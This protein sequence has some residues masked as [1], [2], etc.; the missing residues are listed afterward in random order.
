MRNVRRSG[1]PHR[2]FTQI[3]GAQALANS[4]KASNSAVPG[5]ALFEYEF[6]ERAGGEAALRSAL[7]MVGFD[8]VFLLRPRIDVDAVEA[9]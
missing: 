7:M 4:A 1:S 6:V 3:V 8:H 2:S 9:A 5:T